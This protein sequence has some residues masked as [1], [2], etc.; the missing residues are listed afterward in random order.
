MVKI[1]F[2]RRERMPE[3]KIRENPRIANMP[4]L[5]P[6]AY[7]VEVPDLLWQEAVDGDAEALDELRKVAL[8]QGVASGETYKLNPFLGGGRNTRLGYRKKKVEGMPVLI[9]DFEV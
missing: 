3:D 8:E 7:I 5:W 2:R 1:G 6:N 4:F 9:E